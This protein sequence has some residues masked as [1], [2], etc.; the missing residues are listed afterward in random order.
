MNKA[1]KNFE[2]DILFSSFFGQTVFHIFYQDVKML[3]LISYYLN[4]GLEPEEDL[5]KNDLEN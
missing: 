2:K 1:L 3:N 4:E 5:D